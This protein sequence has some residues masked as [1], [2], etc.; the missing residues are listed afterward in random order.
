MAK[1]L[2]SLAVLQAAMEQ[3]ARDAGLEASIAREVTAS[4]VEQVRRLFGGQRVYMPLVDS[5]ERHVLDA[6]ALAAHRAGASVREIAARLAI[7]KS[8]AARAIARAEA[9]EGLPG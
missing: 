4:A 9:R 3:A 2:S 5:S 7:S 8:E 6:R 1:S